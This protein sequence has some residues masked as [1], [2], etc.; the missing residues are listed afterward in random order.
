MG[1]GDLVW[2]NGQVCLGEGNP[3][4]GGIDGLCSVSGTPPK[5]RDLADKAAADQHTA[6]R[7]APVNIAHFR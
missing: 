3:H 2:S 7:Q 5:A 4:H 6:G 1:D